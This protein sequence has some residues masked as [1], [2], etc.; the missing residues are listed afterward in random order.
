MGYIII[1]VCLASNIY[2]IIKLGL[3]RKIYKVR[4]NMKF[5]PINK[6]C[7]NRL[8]YERFKTIYNTWLELSSHL[9][10]TGEEGQ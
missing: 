10:S 8:D 7:R 4:I 2:N 9:M 5:S 1:E 6:G 3:I